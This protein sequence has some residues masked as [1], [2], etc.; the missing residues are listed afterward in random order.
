MARVTVFSGEYDMANRPDLRKKLDRL[1][2][3]TNV[4][5]DF[6]GVTFVDSACI[7]E[8]IRLDDLRAANELD[9]MTVVVGA[10]G[11]I[12][13]LF[14]ILGLCERFNVEVKETVAV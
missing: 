14:E 4:V 12:H 9:L 2:F 6:S 11:P 5:L 8:L 10:D 1:A 13:R 7:A 3:E